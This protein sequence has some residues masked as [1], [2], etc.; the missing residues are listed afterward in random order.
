ML[1]VALVHVF[2]L[3]IVNLASAQVNEP[4]EGPSYSPVGWTP[5]K[6]S[7][8]GGNGEGVAQERV[9]R[10]IGR[11]VGS[12]TSV[13][14]NDQCPFGMPSSKQAWV[15]DVEEVVVLD[16]TKQETIKLSIAIDES[17]GHLFAVFTEPRPSW[18]VPAMKPRSPEDEAHAAH[19]S[20]SEDGVDAT[21]RA[22]NQILSLIWSRYGIA[23]STPGQ[24]VMRPRRVATRFPA[25]RGRG[26]STPLFPEGVAW[27]V[28]VLGV[29][30]PQS[31]TLYWT[32]YLILVDDNSGRI[33]ETLM[34]P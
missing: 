33:I 10:L 4:K 22:P 15:F 16:E 19:W 32:G 27:I 1:V 8:Q 34:M 24:I 5:T 11:E 25:I 20:V 12:G 3:L 30:V 21:A 23:P 28:Q 2:I 18:V 14:F 6:S 29:H 31:P 26:K 17:N 9:R 13:V 7:S